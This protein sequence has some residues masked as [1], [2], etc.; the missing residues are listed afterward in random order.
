MAVVKKGS[1]TE[2]GKKIEELAGRIPPPLSW[3]VP[4]GYGD[5]T[6]GFSLPF[7]QP[8]VGLTRPEAI[9]Q[10]LRGVLR[11]RHLSEFPSKYGKEILDSIQYLLKGAPRKP[12]EQ[13]GAIRVISPGQQMTIPGWGR[14][15]GT[16]FGQH[17]SLAGQ[18]KYG[19]PIKWPSIEIMPLANPSDTTKLYTLP[20]VLSHELGGHGAEHRILD[21]LKLAPD[22]VP[23][24]PYKEAVAELLGSVSSKKAGIE[25][26]FIMSH[27]ESTG[28]PSNIERVVSALGEYS[29]NPYL[30]VA[31]FLEK[32]FKVRGK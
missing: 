9:N 3:M 32:Y 31:R 8:V 13:L 26:P 27:W 11:G 21:R 24:S 1:Q 19:T 20:Q 5:P 29:D 15:T 16:S 23:Y 17:Q 22:D 4:Q 12:L 6:G 10:L 25:R 28:S 18:Y 7:T 2:V 14:V 30:G